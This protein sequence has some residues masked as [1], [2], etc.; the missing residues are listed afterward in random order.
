MGVGQDLRKIGTWCQTGFDQIAAC[1]KGASHVVAVN[2]QT[3]PQKGFVG[4]RILR[5]KLPQSVSPITLHLLP[6]RE[7]V[8]STVLVQ[9]SS[10]TWQE[11]D[12]HQSGSYLVFP[13]ADDT[14]TVA[15]VEEIPI[16]WH[17]IAIPFALAAI[18]IIVIL[19]IRKKK[20]K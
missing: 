20:A 14:C 6:Q 18:V 19:V 1:H 3:F 17:L 4:F 13:V 10:G 5:R 15:L 2:R 7:A 9:N 8:I 16:P 11:A 12:F